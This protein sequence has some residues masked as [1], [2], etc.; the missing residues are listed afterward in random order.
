[1]LEPLG[2]TKTRAVY[3]V[4]TDSGVAAPAFVA[5][6]VSETGISKLFAA[7]RKQ[8]KEPKYHAK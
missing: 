1:L 6:N 8:A 4:F 3:S 5:N 7:V 2:A